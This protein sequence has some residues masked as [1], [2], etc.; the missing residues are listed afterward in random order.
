MKM[1][2][3]PQIDGMVWITHV[4]G[5]MIAGAIILAVTLLCK[6]KCM[7]LAPHRPGDRTAETKA[8]RRW[9]VGATALNGSGGHSIF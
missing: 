3:W 2:A 1:A 6:G 8:E 7:R 5:A 9:A 4:V